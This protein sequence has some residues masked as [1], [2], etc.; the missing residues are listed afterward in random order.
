[1]VFV[2]LFSNDQMPSMY[3]IKS[4]AEYANPSLVRQIR[5]IVSIFQIQLTFF[6]LAVAKRGLID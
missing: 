3:W 5:N 2:N 1:V 4:S 6:Q